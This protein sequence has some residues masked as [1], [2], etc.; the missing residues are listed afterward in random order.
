MEALESGA[1]VA[2]AVG[3]TAAVSARARTP[4]DLRNAKAMKGSP[5]IL[6]VVETG[7]V[8][9]CDDIGRGLP[10]GMRREA[11]PGPAP[12]CGKPPVQVIRG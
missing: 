4:R 11:F 12:R 6:R 9:P 2:V 3:R 5:F 8:P 10:G 7:A 1:A